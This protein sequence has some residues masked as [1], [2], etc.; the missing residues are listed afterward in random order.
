MRPRILKSDRNWVKVLTQYL[1]F[2]EQQQ[3]QILPDFSQICTYLLQT[4]VYMRLIL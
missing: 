4:G 2:Q 3:Q 1:T